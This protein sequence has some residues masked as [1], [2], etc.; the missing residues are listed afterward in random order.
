MLLGKELGLCCR[1]LCPDSSVSILCPSKLAYPWPAPSNDCH[2]TL[3]PPHFSVCLSLNVR[4]THIYIYISHLP[5]FACKVVN[6]ICSPYIAIT[7]TS[8]HFFFFFLCQLHQ[9]FIFLSCPY[10]WVFS[11]PMKIVHLLTWTSKINFH[12]PI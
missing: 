6:Y 9:A 1:F 12:Q 4:F 11:A 5:F 3:V 2:H 7:I 8:S 10:K